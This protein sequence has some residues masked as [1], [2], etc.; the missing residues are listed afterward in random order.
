MVVIP[1]GRFRMGSPAS[2]VGRY[3]N[4]GP[5]HEVVVR[6]PF[7]LG[8]YHVTVGEYRAFATA[9]GRGDGGQCATWNGT[10]WQYQTGLGWRNPGFSQTDRDP[11][12]CVSWEDGQAYAQWL[13]GRTGRGYRLPTEAEWEY[14]ARGGTTT[15]WWWGESEAGQCGAANGADQSAREA[16]PGTSGWVFAPCRDGFAYTS[17]VGRF[18]ANRF[19]LSDMGGNAWQWVV[20]CYVAGYS[21]ASADAT[22]ANFGGDC[23]SRAL[24]GG[25]WNY[26][27][28]SSRSASRSWDGPWNRNASNGFRLAR[29][30]G[31]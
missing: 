20:D 9:T 18:A 17:P 4:E 10:Q 12:V 3:D 2:E 27:P 21:G 7:A 6:S 15:R 28:Q 1:A 5:Q 30:P 14:A 8:R 31:R 19:G 13:S 23:A 25:S 16:V 24:R 22:V 29:S 26:G 11:V